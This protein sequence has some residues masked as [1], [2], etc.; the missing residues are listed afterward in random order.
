M[1]ELR[2]AGGEEALMGVG[3][4][5]QVFWRVCAAIARGLPVFAAVL[6]LGPP[7]FCMHGSWRE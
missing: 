2:G 4:W 1:E 7:K 6:A 5:R 3:R